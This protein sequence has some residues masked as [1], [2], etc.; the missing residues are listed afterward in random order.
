MNGWP[1][2]GRVRTVRSLAPC[3]GGCHHACVTAT[4][5]RDT[6]SGGPRRWPL[7]G[8]LPAFTRDPLAFF[9]SLRDGYGDWV[10][11]ALGPQRNILVSRPEHAG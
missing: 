3:E 7:L 8:N 6:R 2:A 4:L 9:E 10:P 11:W 1:L 5:P